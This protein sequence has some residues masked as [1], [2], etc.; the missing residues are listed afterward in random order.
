MHWVTFKQDNYS[1]VG[2]DRRC[3][4]GELRAS[5]TSPIPDHKSLSYSSCQRSTHSLSKWIFTNLAL[6]RFTKLFSWTFSITYQVYFLSTVQ[7]LPSNI[8][9][10]RQGH[11]LTLLHNLL[12]SLQMQDRSKVVLIWL[13][14][15]SSMQVLLVC[16]PGTS[17]FINGQAKLGHLSIYYTVFSLM[18]FFALFLTNKFSDEHLLFTWNLPICQVIA[19]EHL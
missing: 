9:W 14:Y 17:Q 8:T 4:I 18:V 13:L 10:P 6:K 1:T 15:N 19:T 2:G 12:K 3:R 7:N 16:L 11:K 5:I